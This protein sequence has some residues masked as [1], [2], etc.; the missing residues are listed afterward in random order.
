MREINNINVLR[1]IRA[2]GPI[3]R[4]EI[5][6]RV[7]L[8]VSTISNITT[9]LL[10]SKIILEVGEGDSSGGRRPNLLDL[11]GTARY[12]F[13]VKVGP[14][15]VWV[16]LLNLRATLVAVE[17]IPFSLDSEA[18]S[19]LQ[20]IADTVDK[21]CIKHKIS[22]AK[23]M[24]IGVST[25][26][27]VSLETGVCLFSPIL[28]WRNVP[29]R[30]SLEKKTRLDVIVENDV[31]AF[32]YG[33]LQQVGNQGLKNLLCVTTGVGVGAGIIIEGKLF[34]GSSGGAGEFGHMSIDMNGPLCNC[35]RRGCLE[36]MASDQYL[37]TQAKEAIKAGE[38]QILGTFDRDGTL[39]P[40]AI[41]SA[42]RVGDATALRLYD[43]LASHLGQGIANLI[44]LLNPDK[45]VIGGE[46]AVASTFFMDRVHASARQAAFP[47]LAENLE[48]T[49]DDGRE[50]A[51]LQGAASF[52]I[53][54][55]FEIPLSE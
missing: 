24:G 52:V 6:E 33:T 34:R 55:F 37:L 51:W 28:G 11:N 26:G 38:S 9:E 23:V 54:R 48:I 4:I 35:G 14:G 45:I 13:G 15:T 47:H 32:A 12:V 27:A 18:E 41:L 44:N 2:D 31:N 46:G 1:V 30:S 21:L 22:R 16:A 36:V 53:E 3:S 49:V 8:G 50:D 19:V 40:S 5:A 7:G 17:E 42:A 29:I 10:E 39:T 43:E 20:L 25:S